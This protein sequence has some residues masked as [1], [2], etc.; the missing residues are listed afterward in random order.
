MGTYSCSDY[1]SQKEESSELLTKILL[2]QKKWRKMNKEVEAKVNPDNKLEGIANEI[3]NIDLKTIMLPV[4]Q[5]IE[6]KV[7]EYHMTESLDKNSNLIYKELL[8]KDDSVYLGTINKNTYQREGDGI[9]Y[10]PDRSKFTGSF[11]RNEPNGIGRIIYPDGAFYEGTFKEGIIHG[12]GK[13]SYQNYMYIGNWKNELKEGY[14]EEF[15]ENGLNFKGYY[16]ND[17]KNGKGK[18]MWPNGRAYEGNFIDSV[19][20]GIGKMIWPENKI[21]IA[22]WNKGVIDGITVFY[23]VDDQRYI[24]DYSSFQKNGF[25]IFYGNKEKYQGTWINGKQHGYGLIKD[26][27]T[28]PIISTNELFVSE[29]RFG[30]KINHITSNNENYSSILKEI[31]EKANQIESYVKKTYHIDGIEDNYF[32]KKMLQFQVHS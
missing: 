27:S 2:I 19:I 15:Y 9:L 21:S 20:H 22:N 28:N 6:A 17:K 10:Y 3:F 16:S 18:L 7:G 11:L 24:G 25:G 12:Y 29:Y 5:E 1:K 13:Y 31:N 23:W 14:G 32:Y 30:I 4:I 8:Y 26:L